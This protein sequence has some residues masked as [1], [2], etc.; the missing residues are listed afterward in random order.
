MSPDSKQFEEILGQV[1]PDYY[2]SG[3]RNNL[4]QKYWHN[5]KWDNLSR[6]LE[7]RRAKL[8]DIGCAD[9]TTT[10]QISRLFPKLQI[11]GVDKYAKAIQY[12]SKTKPHIKFINA[13][14]HKLPFKNNSFDFVVA[15]ET[16]EHLHEPDQALSEIYRVLKKKGYL[17]VVQDTDSLLFRTIWWFWTKWKGSVWNHSHINCLNPKELLKKVRDSGFK[18]KKLGYTNLK[19]EVFIK[20]QK[21]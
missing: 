7:N 12:A 5:H 4:L 10:S 16:L 6:F 11:T 15:I 14:A 1:P 8:L 9:G 17:I 18:V 13:D 21:I 19:M 20:A 3:V 2:D